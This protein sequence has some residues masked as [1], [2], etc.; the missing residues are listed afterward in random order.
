MSELP[1]E[2]ME[3]LER[4]RVMALKNRRQYAIAASGRSKKESPSPPRAKSRKA[5]KP[6]FYNPASRD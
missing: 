6:H 2:I 3:R 4:I 5:A 1:P